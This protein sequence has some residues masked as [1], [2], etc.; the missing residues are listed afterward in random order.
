[1]ICKTL[2]E[3]HT[4]MRQKYEHLCDAY[5][6]A[7]AVDEFGDIGREMLSKYDNPYDARLAAEAVS[8]FGDIGRELL[9]KYADKWFGYVKAK[10][11]P[12]CF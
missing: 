9:A 5:Y 3:L 12:P 6:A 8:E 10:E 2:E 1:M 11:A 4:E 7:S